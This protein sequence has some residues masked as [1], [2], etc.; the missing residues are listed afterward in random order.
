MVFLYYLTM[1][2]YQSKKLRCQQLSEF[3]SV[4]LA[5]LATNRVLLSEYA[6]YNG[7]LKRCVY[8]HSNFRRF[9]DHDGVSLN[10]VGIGDLN[11]ISRVDDTGC[12]GL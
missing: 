12:L 2:H 1:T 3:F 9:G 11:H 5:F 10:P 6:G 8:V 4:I 7:M